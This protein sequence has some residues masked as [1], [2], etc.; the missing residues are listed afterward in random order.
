MTGALAGERQQH[1]ALPGP[2]RRSSRGHGQVGRNLVLI[3]LISVV[4]VRLFTDVLAVAPRFLNFIDAPLLGILFLYA[5]VGP[6]GKVQKDRLSSPFRLALGLLLLICLI[7]T[8][9]HLERV[10]AGPGMLFVYGYVSPLLIY[11][12]VLK[13]WPPG[14]AGALVDTLIS[15]GILQLLIVTFVQLPRFFGAGNNPDFITGTFGENP[16]QLVIFLLIFGSLVAAMSVYQPRHLAARLK[17][18]L[19]LGSF[20]VIFLAQFRAFLVTVA[21]VVVV[22]GLLI[23]QRTRWHTNARIRGIVTATTTGATLA[24]GF[25]FVAIVYPEHKLLPTVGLLGEQRSAV[26]AGK[27]SGAKNVW[28][29]Y[30]DEPSAVVAGTGPG[31]YSSRAWRTFSVIGTGQTVDAA[32][33]Y[34]SRFL[35]QERYRTDVADKY[36]LP[37]LGAALFGSEVLAQPWSSFLSLLAEVGLGGFLVVTGAYA[38]AFLRCRQMLKH[39]L[40]Y[41]RSGDPLPGLLVATAVAIFV[42]VQAALLDNWLESTRVTFLA[43][44]CLAVCTKEFS[45]RYVRLDASRPTE[46]TTHRHGSL[47]TAHS[48]R[49]DL[50]GS[51]PRQPVPSTKI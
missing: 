34:A 37:Q 51:H 32:G 12:V 10:A 39:T 21:L 46:T 41:S 36:V 11:F 38:V 8:L 6:N 27:L 15:L 13:I 1:V 40:R 2:L 7:S 25:T 50:D 19:M 49:F 48:R 24:I 4:V 43:W 44:T 3:T 28:R 17:I 42:L 16:Y 33:A 5:I 31:T 29:L 20:L 47:A 9:T 14:Q 22:T 18:P 26:L 35:G 45:A 30:Q 23:R